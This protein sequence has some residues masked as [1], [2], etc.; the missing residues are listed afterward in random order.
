[1]GLDAACCTV[2]CCVAAVIILSVNSVII[3]NTTT[4]TAQL[5]SD[6]SEGFNPSGELSK[7]NPLMLILC[8]VECGV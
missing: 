8:H 6:V 2:D 4:T 7:N 5:L 1:M 3:M